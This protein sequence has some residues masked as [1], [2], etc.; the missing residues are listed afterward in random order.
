MIAPMHRV[1][2]S[3]GVSHN[4]NQEKKHCT[5]KGFTNNCTG[6]FESEGVSHNN[7]QDANWQNVLSIFK[8]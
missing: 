7:D 8:S 4:N 1:L 2:Q 3:E 5:T 6:V